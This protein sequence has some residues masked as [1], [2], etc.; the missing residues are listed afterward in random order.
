MEVIVKC[1][2]ETSDGKKYVNENYVVVGSKRGPTIVR[3]AADKVAVSE[4]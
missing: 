4:K 3:L 2:V 1:H